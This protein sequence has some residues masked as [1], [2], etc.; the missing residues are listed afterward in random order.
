MNAPQPAAFNRPLQR[1]AA[2]GIDSLYLSSFIDGVGIG[3]ER[4]R[5]EKEKLH[6]TPGAEFTEF[7]LG[8]EK[9]GLK[10]GGRKPYSFILKNRAFELQLGENIHPRCHAQFSSELLWRDGLD[11]ALERY[12]AMWAK[13]GTRETRPEV[14]ARVDVAFDFEI[15]TP[16][17][18]IDDFVSVAGKDSQWREHR[19][20]QTFM[21]GKS[22]TVC[23]CYDKV[24]EI[25]QQS[26]KAWLFDIWGVKEGVWRCEYQ[27]RG[28]RLKGAG[29]ATIDQLRAHLPSLTRELARHH[30]SLRVPTADSNR[31]RWPMHSMWIALIDAADDLIA[32][33]NRAPL[34]FQEGISFAL[35]RQCQSILGDLKGLAALLSHRRPNEPLSLEQTLNWLSRKLRRSHSPELW[36]ADV[37]EKIRKRE[38]QL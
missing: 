33:P 25:A 20:P 2:V 8:G 28:E 18:G 38:L 5:Y 27:I 34:P 35:E 16:D 12:A 9:F 36:K 14:I 19:R 22:D 23:R 31:S 26:G 11:A 3:W 37:M 29:I 17:F 7:E 30:T 1:L 24:A 13:V 10:R 15:G 6:A 21:Y 32:P 4:L